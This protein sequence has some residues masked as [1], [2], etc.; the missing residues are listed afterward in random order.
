MKILRDVFYVCSVL[1][2]STGCFH[3]PDPRYAS[4]AQAGFSQDAQAC[5]AMLHPSLNVS[6]PE[7]IPSRDRVSSQ[8]IIITAP[9]LERS[10]W[11]WPSPL[12]SVH[13][14]GS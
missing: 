8:S 14:T 7:N 11:R 2:L 4:F 13:V 6:D 3:G 10:G 12:V 1:F 5:I 9:D